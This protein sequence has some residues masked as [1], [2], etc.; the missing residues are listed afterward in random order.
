MFLQEIT[1][2]LDKWPVKL[3]RFRPHSFDLEV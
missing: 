1:L 3:E 2:R